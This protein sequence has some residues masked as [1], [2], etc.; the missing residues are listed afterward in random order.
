MRR[1]AW[2]AARPWAMV[3]PVTELQVIGLFWAC[4]GLRAHVS[5]LAVAFNRA[6]IVRGFEIILPSQTSAAAIMR[7]RGGSDGKMGTIQQF[8]ELVLKTKLVL[9]TEQ[10]F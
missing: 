1:E 2:D 8:A 3:E 10:P 5:G 7:M 6:P 9:K 4:H